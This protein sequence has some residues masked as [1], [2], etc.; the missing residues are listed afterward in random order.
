VEVRAAPGEDSRDAAEKALLGLKTLV[1]KFERPNQ[2]Y[3]SRSAPQ[4]VHDHAGDYGH[5]A[6]VFEWST[7][8]EGE[9]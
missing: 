6:R 9:E 8:G 4:F 3:L 1:E 7:S 5:L 2:P